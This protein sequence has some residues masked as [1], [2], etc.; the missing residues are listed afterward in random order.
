MDNLKYLTKEQLLE[1]YSELQQEYID[2]QNENESLNDYV[3]ELEY[4]NDNSDLDIADLVD[5]NNVILDLEL[6][7]EKLEF[8]DLK[9]DKLFDFIDLYMKLYNKE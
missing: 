7:K 2:L 8:Y 1:R 3:S 6:F 5:V 4:S 9:T